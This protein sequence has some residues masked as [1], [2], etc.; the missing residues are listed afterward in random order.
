[1]APLA[2]IMSLLL[3]EHMH[4][5][6]PPKSMKKVVDK[7]RKWLDTKGSYILG[8]L[9]ENIEYQGSYAK[10]AKQLIDTLS[11]NSEQERNEAPSEDPAENE[12]PDDQVDSAADQE[13]EPEYHAPDPNQSESTDQQ[14]QTEEESF[15]E[16]QSDQRIDAPMPLHMAPNRP[17]VTPMK[18][19]EPYKIFTNDFDEVIEADQLASCEEMDTYRQ[20]LDEKL[21]QYQNV[22]S[23]LAARLQ[24]LLLARQQREWLYDL[25]DGLIDNA[26]LARLIVHPDMREIYKQEQESDFRDS[27]VSLL[28]DNSGSMR[29]R[30]ITIA[31][32]SADIL[33]RTLERCGVKIEILGF[34]T[35]DWKGGQARKR[36]EQSGR[37]RSPG[38]LN[39][40]RHIIYKSADMRLN[41]TR[42]NLGLMLKDGVLKENIDGEALL[43]AHERLLARPEQ[44]RILM[45]ISDG[46]PVDDSTLSI[47]SSGYLDRHLRDVIDG[48]EN[49]SDVELVAIGI[50]HDVTRYYKR[51]VTIHEVEQLGDTMMKEIT[52]LFSEDENRRR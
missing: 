12:S 40:L 31:A 35:R 27:V 45:V 50:G 10:Y 18:Q 47:N 16:S 30:P 24:R 5:T 9:E 17:S 14:E 15:E 8:K 6:P 42:R 3:R 25:E 43:W 7:W 48:I 21:K 19:A 1:E 32:L 46:A 41:K 37:R 51:A 13:E 49:R 4:G 20:Q 33:A 34:T 23:R 36:W 2:E 38:R 29:G 26:R 39:D 11:F 22:H 28:I 44:R 52:K